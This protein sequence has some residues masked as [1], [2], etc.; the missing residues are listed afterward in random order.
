ME[1]G[2]SH[3]FEGAS[4]QKSVNAEAGHGAQTSLRHPTDHLPPVILL[5]EA[6]RSP[7][8]PS[9][10]PPCYFRLSYFSGHSTASPP[11]TA[12]G[13][14]WE[15]WLLPPRDTAYFSQWNL[16]TAGSV[17]NRSSC[18]SIPPTC[19]NLWRVI[20]SRSIDTLSMNLLAKWVN[21]CLEWNNREAKKT[22]A[23]LFRIIRTINIRGD[24]KEINN[25][26][27]LVGKKCTKFCVVFFKINT[28]NTIRVVG[29]FGKFKRFLRF[30][31]IAS[32]INVFHSISNNRAVYWKSTKSLLSNESIIFLPSSFSP[33]QNFLKIIGRYVSHRLH[34]TKLVQLIELRTTSL[35]VS[36]VSES[37]SELCCFLR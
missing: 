5:P 17:R 29:K 34:S 8:V 27:N 30:Q 36:M 9:T 14:L 33:F 37:Q 1:H 4:Y 28:E 12:T 6:S 32:I 3:L 24:F 7:G 23:F 18:S 21:E 20:T 2:S 15:K 31:R 26:R 16:P 11:T 25:G 22:N 10:Y 13:S 19:A 35:L